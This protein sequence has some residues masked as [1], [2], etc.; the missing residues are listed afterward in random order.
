MEKTTD[1]E[2]NDSTDV[3]KLRPFMLTEGVLQDY[4]SYVCKT[5]RKNL[6]ATDEPVSSIDFKKNANDAVFKLKL[7][8]VGKDWMFPIDTCDAKI[9][10]AGMVSII[11]STQF[12]YKAMLK[13]LTVDGNAG[14][15]SGSKIIIDPTNTTMLIYSESLGATT[16][17]LEKRIGF[18]WG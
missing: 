18:V 15:I 10:K 4:I 3:D 17:D 13:K 16:R 14:I 2:N 1:V 5:S 9:I 11:N 7:A 6:F 8:I 12:V